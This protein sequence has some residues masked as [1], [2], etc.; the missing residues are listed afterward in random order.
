MVLEVKKHMQERRRDLTIDHTSGTDAGRSR[1]A[2]LRKGRLL[3]VMVLLAGMLALSWVAG[4]SCQKDEQTPAAARPVKKV[5]KVVT[6]PLCGRGVPDPAAL[7]RRPVAIKVENDPAARPQSGLDRACLVYEEIT[8]GGI[9]RFMAIYLDREADPVGPVRSARPV[10]IDLVFPYGALF[11]HCGA[12]DPV[13]VMI[14]QAG[15][16]DIDEFGWAGAFWRTSDRRAPYNLYTSAARIRQA[17]D[18][19]YPFQQVV[20]SPFKFLT[21]V[22]VAKMVKA[23]AAEQRRAA[24]AAQNATQSATQSAATEYQ[25]T[26]AVVNNVVIPYESACTVTWSYDPATNTFARFVAGVPH[27]DRISGRQL[28]ADTVIVQYVV[29]APS[30]LYDVNGAMSSELGALGSGR[31]QVFVA[32]QVIDG[33]WQKSAR[34]QH[35]RF[36]DNA[37]REVPIKPGSTWI[38]LVPTTRQAAVS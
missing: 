18:I 14:K 38:E 23:R 27:T 10:D 33:N 1:W 36:Y 8:E 26:V 32:G 15:L 25:P 35:T 11:A 2:R 31:A 29:E 22:G 21:D 3:L 17:G 9:T 6:C 16:L 13:L 37:G 12:G 19:S 5:A 24:S 30:G 34:E 4:C 7:D 20:S 28:R